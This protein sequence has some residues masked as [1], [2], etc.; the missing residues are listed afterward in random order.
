MSHLKTHLSLIIVSLVMCS[1]CNESKRPCLEEAECFAGEYCTRAGTCAP[2]KGKVITEPRPG[3][4]DPQLTRPDQGNP[5]T[6]KEDMSFPREDME[7]PLPIE[8]MGEQRDQ[9]EAQDAD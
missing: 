9:A 3:S 4:K 8:D 2:Y 1:A 6:P 5:F 7:M